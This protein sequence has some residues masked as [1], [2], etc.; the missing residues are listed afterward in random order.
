MNDDTMTDAVETAGPDDNRDATLTAMQSQ[1]DDLTATVTEH[2]R[3]ID[4]M[5]ASGMLP[6]DVDR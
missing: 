6:P 3:L 2:Q 1:L 4:A 5:F